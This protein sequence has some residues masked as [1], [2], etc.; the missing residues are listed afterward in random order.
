MKNQNKTITIAISILLISSIAASIM[1]VPNTSAHD[2]ALNIPTFAL[3]NA[4]PNPIGV[5]QKAYI[6]MWLTDT[7]DPAS[8]LSNNYR[9]QNYKLTITAPDGHVT[10]ETF[11]TV[12]DPTSAQPYAFTPD[13]V[14]TYSFNFTFPGQQI[15]V[16]NDSPTSVYVNDTYLPSSAVTTLTVQQEAISTLA[17]CSTSNQLLD[18]PNLRHKP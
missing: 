15:T 13:Q 3:I 2:P 8:A 17:Y 6:I 16:T 9:F 10:T 5:G 7:Y 4:A 18:T 11:A 12:S 1:L 14:G